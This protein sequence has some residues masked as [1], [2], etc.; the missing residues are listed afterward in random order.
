M[1]VPRTTAAFGRFL[2]WNAGYAFV[3]MPG[4]CCGVLAMSFRHAWDEGA[5]FE[6][7][8][9]LLAGGQLALLVAGV[10]WFRRGW[11][12]LPPAA[13]GAV[14][15]LFSRRWEAGRPYED[16]GPFD[17]RPPVYTVDQV[18][19]GLLRH[20]RVFDAPYPGVGP[21]CWDFIA[22]ALELSLCV[23]L[24]LALAGVAWAVAAWR[25]RREPRP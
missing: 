10:A 6:F 9:C 14:G 1:A 4:A 3:A 15:I 17:H 21:T 7:L 2:L 8:L 12:A 23:W 18:T 19:H 24:T 13:C 5:E 20:L 22:L 11:W 25:E 16:L